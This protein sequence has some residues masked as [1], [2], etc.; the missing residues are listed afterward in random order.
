[1]NENQVNADIP[2]H[3]EDKLNNSNGESL[4]DI[5]KEVT[6]GTKLIHEDHNDE[7]ATTKKH[8]VKV[9]KSKVY[10]N[11]KICKSLYNAFCL[12]MLFSFKTDYTSNNKNDFK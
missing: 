9:N 11:M 10:V 4:S 1:M 5:D 3:A 2:V 7:V 6:D 8:N 12:Y